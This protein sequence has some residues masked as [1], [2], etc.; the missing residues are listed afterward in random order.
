MNEG[1]PGQGAN[2]VA[3]AAKEAADSRPMHW[4][5]RAGLAARGCI[6]LLMGALAVMLAFGHQTE[7]DQSGALTHL[8]SQPFGRILVLLLAIGFGG[9]SLW[10]IS[11]AVFGVTGEGGGAGPRLR[12][13]ASAL[14]YGFLAF[15]SVS[16]L[17]GGGQS[18]SAKQQGMSARVMAHSGGR[19]LV[20]LVGAA[21]VGVAIFM[22]VEGIQGAFMRYFKATSAS[23]RKAIRILGT[24]ANVARGLVFALVGVFVISA[25]W[26]YSPAKAG[27]I[28][29]ALKTMLG[30]WY[31]RPLVMLAALGL[32]TF[33][34]YGLAEARYRKV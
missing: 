28:D 10:R 8:A 6:Y 11:E 17:R 26:T 14:S 2:T 31:G 32:I 30:T 22:I 13:A 3:D 5:A 27:G 1:S 18:Q 16:I 29:A 9:Y 24:T 4:L 12:S 34:I 15:T 25:A 20:G 23:T 19:V 7:V 33:G 21:I